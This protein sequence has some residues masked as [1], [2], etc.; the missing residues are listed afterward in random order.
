MKFMMWI[1]IHII[2]NYKLIRRYDLKFKKM[3]YRQFLLSLLIKVC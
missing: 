3:G 1:I 2:Y